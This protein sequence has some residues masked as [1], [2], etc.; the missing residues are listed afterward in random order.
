VVDTYPCSLRNKAD[1]RCQEKTLLSFPW[2]AARLAQ[3]AVVERKATCGGPSILE[4]TEE[5]LEKVDPLLDAGE[6]DLAGRLMIVLDRILPIYFL[7]ERGTAVAEAIAAT[8]LVA[9]AD[10]ARGL[11][12]GRQAFACT[13]WPGCR[14][15]HDSQGLGS[16]R[17]R[18]QRRKQACLL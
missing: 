10:N 2:L 14:Q 11:L 16:E 1:A 7:R 13:V 18:T 8:C 5:I 9:A 15:S 12:R 17:C 6:T 4:V 3:Q